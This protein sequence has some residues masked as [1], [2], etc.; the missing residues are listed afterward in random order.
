MRSG[1]ALAAGGDVQGNP[2]CRH[3]ERNGRNGQENLD[4]R[5]PAAEPTFPDIEV[6]GC[7]IAE[8]G[9]A[10]R[11]GGTGLAMFPPSQPKRA[12]NGHRDNKEAAHHSEKQLRIAP[13]VEKD[14]YKTM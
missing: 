6:A 11:P 14:P 4:R 5:F 3:A 12:W 2:E 9:I 13:I 8:M 10:L 7:P 1:D